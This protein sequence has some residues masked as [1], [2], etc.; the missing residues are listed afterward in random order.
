MSLRRQRYDTRLP[1]PCAQRLSEVAAED[2]VWNPLVDTLVENQTGPMLLSFLKDT[3]AARLGLTSRLA[4]DIL[5]L[6]CDRAHSVIK[7]V[8]APRAAF[9][10]RQLEWRRHQSGSLA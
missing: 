4:L 5:F 6:Q 3:E 2:K 8:H 10:P 7:L 9:Q 1:A